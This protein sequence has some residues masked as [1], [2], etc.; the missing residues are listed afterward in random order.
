[1][2]CIVCSKLSTIVSDNRKCVQCTSSLKNNLSV[3]CVNCSNNLYMCEI[4][5]KKIQN[6]STVKKCFSCG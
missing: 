2:M 3:L 5:I 1:M 6:K 4:C